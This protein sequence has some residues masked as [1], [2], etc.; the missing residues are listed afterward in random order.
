MN[1]LK[2]APRAWC[3]KID[4]HLLKLGFEKSL[5]EATFYVV[6]K[7]EKLVIVSLYVDD[8]LVTGSCE[9]ALS[10]F[11]AETMSLINMNDL[12]KLSYFLGMEVTKSYSGI[13]IC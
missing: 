8:I 5:S 13:F 3:S 4:D 2:Q 11:K 9:A 6:Q 10:Q 12:G 7:N 1:R